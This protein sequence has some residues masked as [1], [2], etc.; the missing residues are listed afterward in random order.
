MLKIR[1]AGSKRLRMSEL[2]GKRTQKSLSRELTDM[3]GLAYGLQS[4]P[5]IIGGVRQSTPEK[6]AQQTVS[7]I[8]AMSCLRKVVQCSTNYRDVHLVSIF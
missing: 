8:T 1:T 2:V 7:S 6:V 3:P 5:D 4:Y